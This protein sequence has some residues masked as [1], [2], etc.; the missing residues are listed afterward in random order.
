MATED[1][2]PE[3]ERR[4][5]GVLCQGGQSEEIA[6]EILVRL[7]GHRF[8]SVQHQILFDC[9]AALP[10]HR[11]EIVAELAPSRLT[12]AG[13]PDFDMAP[14]RQPQR[15][16]DTDVKQCLEAL[17]RSQRTQSAEADSSSGK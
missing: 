9:L 16:S 4:L 3:I 5:L 17:I 1:S 13:F 12:Q 11:P 10:R 7:R 6:R 15:L 2:I 8:A 14:F